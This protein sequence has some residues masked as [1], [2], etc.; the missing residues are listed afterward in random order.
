MLERVD[1]YEEDE[2]GSLSRGWRRIGH[3]KQEDQ[4]PLR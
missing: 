4:E 3:V 2:R 1:E